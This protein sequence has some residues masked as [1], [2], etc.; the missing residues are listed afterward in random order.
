MVKGEIKP[1]D[2]E[3]TRQICFTKRH[4]SLFNKASELSILCGTM[5]G[6]VVLSTIGTSF[7]FGHPSIDDVVNRFFNSVTSGGGASGG[8][9]NPKENDVPMVEKTTE[10]TIAPHKMESSLA[11]L[12][13]L[14]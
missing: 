3:E 11:L 1:I 10:P 8:A 9:S 14:W 2:N 6:S 12:N 4:Q 5:V 7:S 13:R